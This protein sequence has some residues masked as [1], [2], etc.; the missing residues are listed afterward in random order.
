MR[1]TKTAFR[2][3]EENCHKKALLRGSKCIVS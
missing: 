2:I 1:E 3:P